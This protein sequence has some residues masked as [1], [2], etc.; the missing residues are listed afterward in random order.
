MTDPDLKA[1][2][3]VAD[4]LAVKLHMTCVENE[5]VSDIEAMKVIDDYYEVRGEP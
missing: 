4:V 2:I 1:L 3:K 5:R